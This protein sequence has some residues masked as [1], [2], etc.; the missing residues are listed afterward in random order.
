[1]A[2]GNPI[3]SLEIVPQGL[4]SSIANNMLRV[5]MYQR[6]Y[7][8]EQEDVSNFLTDVNTA[9]SNNET[10]YFM[11][12]IVLQGA[13]H[14]Y[15]VVDGQQRLTTATVFIAAVRDYLKSKGNDAVAESLETRYLLT[16][17]TWTQ[18][19]SPKM[20]LSVY[21]N[22]FFLKCILKNENVTPERESH[23]RLFNARKLCLE[24][25]GN[26]P[27]SYTDWFDRLSK[28]VKYL[29]HKARIIQVIVP[30]ESNAYIIFETL[31]D[32]GK[33]L[34]AS[35]LL[36][37]YLFGRA[38][39]RIE[40]VQT[41]WNKM[42]GILE[43]HGGDEIVITY[44]RQLWSATREVA[45]EKELFAK[46]K[47][48]IVSPQQAVDF[49]NELVARADH[50]SAILSPSHQIWKEIDPQAEVLIQSLSSL[51]LERYR[52]ALLGLLGS[53]KSKELIEAI[54]A[55]LNGSVRYLI[56][57]GAGGG[58]LEAA[59][60][61][62]ARKVSSG[63]ITTAKGVRQELSKI[64]PNDDIFRAAFLTTRISKAYLARY[65]LAALERA[66]RGVENCEL[67]PN[68]EVNYVNLEHILPENPEGNWPEIAPEIAE[69]YSRRLGNLALL[70]KQKNTDIGNESFDKKRKILAKSDFN[71]TKM[72][73]LKESWG[74]KEIDDR[75]AQLA[76]LA[77]KVWSYKV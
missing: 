71:L 45:R 4:G 56:A 22:D 37:N 63:E 53:F 40:E 46:I 58:S 39:E 23:Q 17:D 69:T 21:D 72:V 2:E 27:K 36:K 47:S 62:L 61:D 11:G 3:S 12:A 29:E 5:P 33:D 41:Q 67:V 6:A 59:Y 77:I 42:L 74:P 7:S 73:G 49:A 20:K 25:L 16:K 48:K 14:S 68:E 19:V 50:Y 55:I 60:S 65:F 32:R 24:F 66:S 1:M 38:A 57:I 43:P 9:F 10:E 34:S 64:I 26:L 51:K 15:A 13:E 52:P 70:S 75:Q 54:R 31:N 76:E 28:L 8:W 44:I 18:N 35:D 30:N